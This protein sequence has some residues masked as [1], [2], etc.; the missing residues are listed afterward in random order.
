MLFIDAAQVNKR[1][2]KFIAKFWWKR[3]P[4]S[5]EARHTEVKFNQA[6]FCWSRVQM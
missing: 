3:D 6:V 2:G 4:L 1:Y 5:T